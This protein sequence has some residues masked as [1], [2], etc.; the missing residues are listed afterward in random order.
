MIDSAKDKI[1][2]IKLLLLPEVVK[3][4][5]EEQWLLSIENGNSFGEYQYWLGTEILNKSCKDN[6]RR[7]K[8]FEKA[9]EIKV[10]EIIVSY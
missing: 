1:I 9:E 5:L 6:V 3:K 10:N 7:A 8:D 2:D 4:K